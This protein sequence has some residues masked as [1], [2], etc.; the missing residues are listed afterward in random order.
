MLSYYVSCDKC[1]EEVHISE[2]VLLEHG[3]FCRCCASR[4]GHV[5]YPTIEEERTRMKND[6]SNIKRFP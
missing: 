3:E 4:T 1:G 6:L 5:K 2:L